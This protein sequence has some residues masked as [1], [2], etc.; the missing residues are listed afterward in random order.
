M[1]FKAVF[2]DLDGT[3]IDSKLD[4]D[5]MRV[6]LNFP[7]GSP[8]LEEIEKLECEKEKM[9]CMEIVN[10]HEHRGA[11][12]S[13]V[14]PGVRELLDWLDKNQIPSGILTR[15]SSDCAK[16]ML[17]KHQLRFEHVLSRDDCLPKPDPAGLLELAKKNSVIPSDCLYVGDYLFDLETARNAGMMSA[18]YSPQDIPDFAERADY[19]FSE[20]RDFIPS[21]L[22]S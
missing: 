4:F 21:I 5:A 2:F 11:E 9:K 16:F 15:N 6:D 18:L 3:L 13:I 8:I 12:L 7:E 1:K 14:I 20:Y 22:L 17:E 19:I 10:H